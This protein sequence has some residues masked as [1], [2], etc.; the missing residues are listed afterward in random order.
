MNLPRT[1]RRRRR[2]AMVSQKIRNFA[3]LPQGVS[4]EKLV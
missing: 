2:T 4:L 1:G 3:P